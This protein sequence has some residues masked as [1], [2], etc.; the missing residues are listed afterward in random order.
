VESRT[1][2]RLEHQVPKTARIWN[3]PIEKVAPNKNQPRKD[4]EKEALEELK[5]SI[6]QKGILQPIVVREKSKDEFEIIAGERRW[7]A[8]QLAGLDEIPVIIKE[9]D[10]QNALE[11]ALIENI[12][13]ED[14]NPIEEAQAY[15]YLMDE[16]ALTQNELAGKVGKERATVANVMRLLQLGP[17][18]RSM[19][20]QNLLSTGQGKALLSVSDP[21]A[22]KRLARKAAK[23]K[24]SVRAVEKM[25][26]K[27][28][29]EL[30]G[31]AD[32]KIESLD[33]SGKLMRGLSDELQK[34]IRSKVTIDYAG[35]KGKVSMHFYSDD[36]LNQFVDKI[37]QTWQN[38]EHQS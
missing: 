7:R 14:L 20:S 33:V 11:L 17:E 37:R 10:E 21:K 30:A 26:Q 16:Y 23:Q 8:S 1:E 15:Q 13:R 12:Q 9:T 6:E 31:T 19:I 36:E 28:K 25:V 18:V 2:K 32:K 24:M 22:Q 35:G 4:F 38:N 3:V 29:N 5:K 34:I 27:Y